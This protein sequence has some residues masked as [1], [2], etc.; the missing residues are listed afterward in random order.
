MCL[1]IPGRVVEILDEA[2]QLA[3]VDVAASGARSTSGCSTS[4]TSARSAGEWVLIHVGFALSRIDE[5][6]GARD[7]R[8]A[9]AD[10]RGLR[11]G[12][13]A[14]WGERD[15]AAAAGR[16]R[17]TGD[18]HAARCTTCGDIAA[19]DARAERATRGSE[20]ARLRRRGRARERTVDTGLRR[21]GRARARRCSSTPAPRSRRRA[22]RR[23][24]FAAEFRDAEL[25]RALGGRDRVARRAGAHLQAD[26][27]VRRAHPHDLPLRD[28]RRCC[29]RT[30]ELVHGPGCP[31][32]VLPMGRV[33]DAHRDRAPAGGDPH[34]LRRHDAGARLRPAACSRRRRTAPT[35]AWSTRR[36]TRSRS[37]ASNP[38]REVVFFAIGFE[39]TAPSTALTLQAREGARASRTSRCVCNHVTIEPPLRAL[40]R[41]ARARDRRLHRARPRRDGGRRAPVRVHPRE[42]RQP[43]VD[44]RA[45]SRSTCCSRSRCSCASSPRGSCEV[46]NQYARVVPWEGNPR[47]RQV[48]AEVFAGAPALRVARARLHLP[49]RPATLRR[50]RRARRRAALR[51]LPGVR[52]ADP[53]AC[54]CGEVLKGVIKPW[55]CKVFGTACTPGAA[56]RHVHGLAGGGVRRLLQLRRYAARARRWRCERRN[57][58]A[59]HARDRRSARARSRRA[60]A[61]SASRWPTAPA[62]RPRSR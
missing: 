29:P 52:V 62:A 6:R 27:G 46:E 1:A 11:A 55:E 2:D 4:R 51:D 20:L 60:S 32:C 12:A 61:T 40:L 14:S 59:A 24:R 43:I 50:L 22:G 45:S 56:D 53:T 37:P 23:M 18:G 26:G 17:S 19:S 35:C 41:L 47:A 7:A 34:L 25:G 57:A 31:V 16:G 49:Q 58:R 10:G 44:L 33:D 15:R 5:E 30:V 3:Q 36:S 39:T 54:Q 21:R 28:R 8:A 38:D 42:L 13:R 9:R 48:M